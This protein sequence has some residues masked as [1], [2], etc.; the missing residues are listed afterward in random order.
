MKVRLKNNPEIT[1]FSNTFNPASVIEIIV[2]YDDGGGDSDFITNYEVLIDDKWIDMS[3]AFKNH[4][5]ITDNY[6]TEFFEPKDDEER[7]RGYRLTKRDL[8]ELKAQS[9]D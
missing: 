6:N 5:L 4:D 2:M 7:K 1:G 9:H 3:D 8:A